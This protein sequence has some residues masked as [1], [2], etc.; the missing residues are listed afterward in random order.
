MVTDGDP[1]ITLDVDHAVYLPSLADIA[2]TCAAIQAGWS[3]DDRA[4]RTA[5]KPVEWSVPIISASVRGE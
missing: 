3:D 5:M 4:K 2:A 1:I